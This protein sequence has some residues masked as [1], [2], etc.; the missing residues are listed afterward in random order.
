EELLNLLAKITQLHVAARTSSFSFKGQN[1]EVPEI[2]RRL[3]VAHVLEGSIRKAGDQVRIT[4]QLIRA[5]D[6]YHVWSET[7]DRKLD[8]IFKIQ[9]E[10]AGKVV[11]ALKVTLLTPVPRAYRMS[12]KAVQVGG[13]FPAEAFAKSDELYRQALAIDPNYAPAWRGMSVN[14]NGEPSIG[15]IPSGEAAARSREAANKALA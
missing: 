11:D 3:H 2:A 10:I 14:Y 1:V 5:A 13:K 9:D 15:M 7:W 12:R 4:A 6:G 8:D